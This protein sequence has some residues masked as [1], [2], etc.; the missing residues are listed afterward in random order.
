MHPRRLAAVLFLAVVCLA[1]GR[2]SG[3][4]A[5][6]VVVMN[7]DDSG[8]GSLRQAIDDATTGTGI[9]FAQSIQGQTIELH[10]PLVIDSTMSIDGSDARMT[11]KAVNHTRVLETSSDM[12]LANLNVEGGESPDKGGAILHTSGQFNFHNSSV[13]NST[14]DTDGGGIYVATGGDAI[15]DEVVI[16]GNSAGR[17]GG[18]IYAETNV[19]MDITLVTITNNHATGNGGGVFLEQ[20]SA[21]FEV[22]TIANNTAA[23][24]AGIFSNGFF[25]LDGT[26]DGNR[27]T[28]AGG[29]FYINAGDAVL[30][31]TT[32]SG[33]SAADGGG[34][35]MQP[36]ATIE[37][38]S[39][40]ITQNSGG[41][42]HLSGG[43]LKI[44][45]TI[46]AEQTTGPGCSLEL[47]VVVTSSG[48]NL[49][50]DTTCPLNQ[51]TDIQR[52]FANLGPLTL[53]PQDAHVKTQAPQEGSDALNRIQIDPD[54]HIAGDGPSDHSV[55]CGVTLAIDARS[56]LR[57]QGPGCEIGA[58]EA[59]Q[60]RLPRVWGDNL[61]DGEIDSGDALTA[62][63][64]VAGV[65]WTRMDGCISVGSLVSG[66][67]L[68]AN[69]LQWAD[70]NCDGV[71]NAFD[72][73]DGLRAAVTL[74]RDHSSAC[75][76]I[77]KD[78][79]LLG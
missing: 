23:M 29:A 28:D 35:E 7:T 13:K 62:L 42:L 40:T 8:P 31:N 58:Y 79:N 22:V 70:V 44:E 59:I 36:G 20:N 39:G 16:D 2:A 55:R 74:P 57:P 71:L 53:D 30:R 63:A 19:S 65:P 6:L 21:T 45:T 3:A 5:A 66:D 73:L 48:Y 24:G 9:L 61:C 50:T 49:S 34:I 72:A 27:A 64:F 26:L 47:G 15:L 12:N 18:G 69:A 37:M 14:A 56:V 51:P 76:Y 33:N 54:A 75:P 4:H 25:G 1:L 78:V 32:I 10:S 68:P 41:G 11:L 77:G 60:T 38:F 67:A 46:I 52:G 43:T 17:N